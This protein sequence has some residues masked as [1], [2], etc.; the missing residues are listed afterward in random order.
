VGTTKDNLPSGSSRNKIEYLAEQ[1]DNKGG[2]SPIQ[3]ETIPE[4]ASAPSGSRKDQ[5]F[6]KRGGG[7]VD[8]ADFMRP[9]GLVQQAS[10]EAVITIDVNLVIS[11][12][13]F[14]NFSDVSK[15]AGLEF[16][17]SAAFNEQS[18]NGSIGEKVPLN[19]V[20][21]G[22]KVI[23][24]GSRTFTLAPIDYSDDYPFYLG[25]EIDWTCT[26]YPF[27][28][29]GNNIMWLDGGLVVGSSVTAG[30]MGSRVGLTFHDIRPYLP[31]S[32]LIE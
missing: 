20:V 22:D 23:A 6:L 26:E 29:Y 30:F 15:L 18:V 7:F 24:K 9:L 31:P 5:F 13:N 1:I 12:A 8:T 2:F 10:Y 17:L 27:S 21:R 32:E 16:T 4:M 25:G 19:V 11:L 28:E 14:A 3:I